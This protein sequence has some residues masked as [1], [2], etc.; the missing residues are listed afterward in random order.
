[1]EDDVKRPPPKNVKET[2]KN[3]TSGLES[4]NPS[5]LAAILFRALNRER[6]KAGLPHVTWSRKLAVVARKYSREMAKTGIVAHISKISGSPSDRL[7]NAHI[8]LPGISEN[9]AKAATAK[10]AHLGLMNSPG[11]RANI[12]D[13]MAAEVGVGVAL[14]TDYGPEGPMVIIT[15]MFALKPK[16]ID[17]VATGDELIAIVNRLRKGR[18]LAPFSTHPW[19]TRTANKVSAT[20]SKTGVVEI[21][22]FGTKF[23]RV[24][25]MV[26]KTMVPAESI[27]SVNQLMDSDETH[28]GISLRICR[29]KKM[30]RDMVCVIVLLGVAI[31]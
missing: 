6:K 3:S 13:I 23:E 30:A 4:H 25:S 18:G 12:L 31:R 8:R 2:A 19:L 24:S 10:E 27:Q 9:L 28:I 17:D 11:H 26:L 29:D 5:D 22:D 16:P 1:L 21:P 20:Y 15:Q 14:T 7:A